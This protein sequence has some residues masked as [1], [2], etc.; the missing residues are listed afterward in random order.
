M[1]NRATIMTLKRKV[2]S[3]HRVV[4]D[5]KKKKKVNIRYPRE[6]KLAPWFSWPTSSPSQRV[7]TN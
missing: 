7:S 3:K 2:S 4:L 6:G 5:L 1:W